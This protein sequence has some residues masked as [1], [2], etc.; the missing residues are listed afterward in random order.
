M[1]AKPSQKKLL[2]WFKSATKPKGNI[3]WAQKHNLTKRNNLFGSEAQP[4]RR[5]YF[6]GSEAQP[7]QRNYFSWSET[8]PTDPEDFFNKNFMTQKNLVSHHFL[9]YHLS[10]KKK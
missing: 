2:V 3:F 7:N 4:T 1:L 10:Q 9:Y 6:F 8:H 5:N